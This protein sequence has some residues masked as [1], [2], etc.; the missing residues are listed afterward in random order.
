MDALL[1]LIFRMWLSD[2][3]F[4]FCTWRRLIRQKW[5]VAYQGQYFMIHSSIS[6]CD[7]TCETGNAELQIGTD[8]STQTR[9]NLRVDGYG[10]GFG[11]PRVCGSGFWSVL[12]PNRPVFA[13]QTWT[14]CGLPGPVAKIVEMQLEAEIEW[15]QGCTLRPSLSEFGDAIVDWDVGISEIHSKA[16]I[17]HV[18]RWICRIRSS[19]LRDAHG[20]LDQLSLEMHWEAVIEWLWR[21][22]WRQRWSELRDTLRGQDRASL[23]MHFEA[24]I[25]WTQRWTWRPWMIELGDA[26]GGR[27][28]GSVEMHFETEIESTQRYTP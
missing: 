22:N 15:T 4:L 21:C 28:R 3:V 5:T 10:S 19:E 26:L 24:E 23:E 27:D 18:W 13:V 16:V 6:G 12:E 1:T 20:G 11:P 7:H 8:G 17:E 2:W 25:E 14:A 9:H